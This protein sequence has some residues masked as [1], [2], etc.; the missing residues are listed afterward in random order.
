VA[1]ASTVPTQADPGIVDENVQPHSVLLIFSEAGTRATSS[2]AF[3]EGTF[4]FGVRIM[5]ADALTAFEPRKTPIQARATVTVEAI[6]EATIQILLSQGA[7]RL[8]TTRVA[9]R[10]GVSVGTLYQYF[11]NKQS[12]LFAVL[13][14]HLEKVTEAVEHACERA[15]HKPLTEMIKEVVE[16]FVDAKIA[17]ADISVALYKVAPDLG[18]LALLKRVTQRLGKALARMLESAPD[19]RTSP[20]E[21]AIQVMLA[22]MSGAMRSVLETGGSPVMMRKV[23]E[24]LVLL[25]RSYMWPLRPSAFRVLNGIALDF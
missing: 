14:D 6:S 5:A 16:A 13:E 8:T 25:C 23:R 24:H 20:D 3:D 1:N 4:S 9:D 12:L 7:E 11:P 22:A 10:A 15:R 18:V 2:N 21:F 19:T 17:R